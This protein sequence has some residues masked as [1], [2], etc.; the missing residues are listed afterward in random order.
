MGSIGSTGKRALVIR[1]NTASANN[2][3]AIVE[4]SAGVDIRVIGNVLDFIADVI[5]AADHG[6]RA[7]C[8]TNTKQN[9]HEL[10]HWEKILS[11]KS[12]RVKVVSSAVAPHPLG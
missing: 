11:W 7:E 6:H 10:L 5:I 1:N 4:D 9:R 2:R 8:Q 3:G 12:V